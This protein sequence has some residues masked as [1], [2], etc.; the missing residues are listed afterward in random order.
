MKIGIL[1]SGMIGATIAE[2]LADAGHEVAIANSRGP[3]TIE[4]K[5]LSTGARAV[6]AADIAAGVDVLVLSVPLNRLADVASI[7]RSAPAGAVV[8]DTSNYYPQR[9]GNIEELQAG[10]VESLWVVRQ[11]GR[12]VIKAW[13]AIGA[14]SFAD[15]GTAAGTANRIAIPVA[16]DDV[17]AKALALKLVDD[18]GFDAVDAGTLAD[19]WQQ[20]PGTPAYCTD[21]T[22]AELTAA[23]PRAD[24]ARSSRRRDI[25]WDA[26]AERSEAD[27]AVGAD[28]LVRLNRALY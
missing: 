3:E 7:V 11:V 1:G 6:D 19:S 24:A 28:Y 12:A 23:L 21:L 22:A 2:R 17:D 13:N 25:A 9:D 15:Y 20:Q 10:E 4:A 27:G 14:Y 16:G 8:L 18:A 26:I 5:V